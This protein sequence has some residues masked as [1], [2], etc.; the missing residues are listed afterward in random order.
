LIQLTDEMKTAINNALAD[1]APIMVA[2]V[3]ETGQPSMSFRGSTQAYSDSQLAIWARNP[4][5][6]LLK[7]I[8][9]NP[10]IAL[11]YRNSETRVAYLIHGEARRDDTEAVKQHVYDHAP[12]VERNADAERKGAAI[13]VDVVRVIQR[14]Q[15]LMER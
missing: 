2:S 11:M 9:A 15:V 4:E 3:D 13:I 6:G 1:R 8:Q 10:K 14:G 5:G 7:S 12:E